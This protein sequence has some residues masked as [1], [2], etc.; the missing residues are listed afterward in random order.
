[1]I[2]WN[3]TPGNLPL[4]KWKKNSSNLTVWLASEDSLAFRALLRY[5]FQPKAKVFKSWTFSFFQ[6]WKMKLRLIP[7]QHWPHLYFLNENFIKSDTVI[8]LVKTRVSCPFWEMFW[9]SFTFSFYQDWLLCEYMFHYSC[10]CS[11]TTLCLLQ[12]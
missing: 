4:T 11:L 7:R 6:M 8:R 1:M 3:G 12:I 9:P 5:G 10:Y 2:L